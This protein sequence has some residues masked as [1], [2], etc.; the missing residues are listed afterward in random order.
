[1]AAFDVVLALSTPDSIRNLPQKAAGN[2]EMTYG[3]SPMAARTCQVQVEGYD[4]TKAS[5]FAYLIVPCGT[6]QQPQ[7]T[8]KTSEASVRSLNSVLF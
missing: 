7:T 6:L 1:M 8:I 2:P 3:V 5:F 4:A